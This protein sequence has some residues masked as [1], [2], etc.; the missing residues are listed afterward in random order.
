MGN[1]PGDLGEYWDTIYAHDAFFGGCVW[2]FTDHSVATGDNIYSNPDYTYGGDYGEPSDSMNLCIDGLAYPDRKP[3]MGLLE[4]KQALR[5]F[6]ILGYNAVSGALTIRNMRFFT[7]LSDYDLLWNLEKDGKVIASGKICSLKIAPSS[8]KTYKIRPQNVDIN[9]ETYLNLSLRLNTPTEWCDAGYEVGFEQIALNAEK[10]APAQ[11]PVR[12]I[13]GALLKIEDSERYI[14]VSTPATVYKFDKSN[15]ALVSVCDN[16][17]ELLASAVI[18][19]VWRAPTDN[20]RR[21]KKEWIKAG[22]DEARAHCRSIGV[23]SADSNHVVL[24]A[25][26][27]IGANF[28]I[29]FINMSVEYTITPCGGLVVSTHADVRNYSYV[30]KTPFLPRFGFEFLMT[31]GTEKLRYFGMGP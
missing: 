12:V 2:K 14:N 22:F 21:I 29:P 1:S 30:D 26:M 4:Y 11:I 5:P 6:R 8:S 9:G 18:P 20:D 23:V 10:P 3:H 16:G 7:T 15:G 24:R 25:E 19:T 31:A 17:R 28:R 13:G 27:Y